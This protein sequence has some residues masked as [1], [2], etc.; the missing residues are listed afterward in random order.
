[1]KRGEGAAILGAAGSA[2]RGR[3]VVGA[4]SPPNKWT[5][6]SRGTTDCRSG[7]RR[8][9]AQRMLDG[10]TPGAPLT[11]Q[12]VRRGA[13]RKGGVD[14]SHVPAVLRAGRAQEVCDRVRHRA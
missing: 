7:P 8:K 4:A 5:G 6:V 11:P 13:A 2:P 12:W 1:M 10:R 14:G 3:L 9:H